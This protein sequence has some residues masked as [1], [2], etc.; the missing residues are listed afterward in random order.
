MLKVLL[1][2]L[3]AVAFSASALLA[4]PANTTIVGCLYQAA[5]VTTADNQYA[6]IQ[7][8]TNGR[9]LT[10][11]NIVPNASVGGSI[12]PT[13]TGAA[14]NNLV[15]K[16]SAGNLFTVTATNL[17]VTA[18]FLTVLNLASSPADGA[19]LPLACVPLPASST[20]TITY[21]V[22]ARYSVGITAVITSAATCFTKTTGVVT[23]FISGQA[24]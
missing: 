20:A 16:A 10:N 1:T 6:N 21:A 8:D 11:N 17:T 14:A 15:L 5:P 24:L 23:A 3:G 19:I 4:Q 2:A 22:P 7:C 18:A 9:L 12:T 13:A